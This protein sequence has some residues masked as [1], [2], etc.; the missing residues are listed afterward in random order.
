M[1]RLIVINGAN[2]N[3]LGKREPG[4]YGSESLEDINKYIKSYAESE[5]CATDFFQSN[6]EGDIVTKI[7]DSPGNYDG[8]ILNAAAFTHYSIAI[9][10]AISSVSPLPCVE[11]HCSNVHAR[12]EFRHRSVISAVCLGQICGF[13]KNSYILAVKALKEYLV[14]NS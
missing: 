3:M 13:G 11:V 7:Q 10:D 1:I 9:R 5:G 2:M 12:E 4:V 14:K 8:I 6:Y